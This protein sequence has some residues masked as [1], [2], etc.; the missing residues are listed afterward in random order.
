VI[1]YGVS[2]AAADMGTTAGT[3]RVGTMTISATDDLYVNLTGGDNSICHGDSGGPA[4]LPIAGKEAIVGVTSVGPENCA[5][6]IG[7]IDT[8]T[9]SLTDFVDGY[10]DAN[11]PPGAGKVGDSCSTN[12][13]CASQV[14][15]QSGGTSYC[16]QRCD[17]TVKDVCPSGYPCSQ[18]DG[19]HFCAPPHHGC[20]VAAG[21]PAGGAPLWL[22]AL[23]MLAGVRS[24]WH[25]A[26]ARGLKR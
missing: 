10:V 15:G 14:C 17:P 12:R 16:S 23:A 19:E 20:D 13:D 21:A 11:D 26:R 3:R 1:G 2:S 8:N 18:I 9:S 7:G 22:L 4:L 24:S 6:S 25:R 5:P